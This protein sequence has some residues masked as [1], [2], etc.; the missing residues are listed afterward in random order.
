MSSSSSLGK[1]I[2]S[3]LHHLTL[4]IREKEN[5]KRQIDTNCIRINMSFYN[6]DAV[7]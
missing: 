6:P 4:I 3:L 1:K 7:R 2:Q 5:E